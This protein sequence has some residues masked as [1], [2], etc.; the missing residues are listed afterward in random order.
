MSGSSSVLSPQSSSPSHVH[1]SG[2]HLPLP[3]VCCRSVHST[4]GVGRLVLLAADEDGLSVETAKRNDNISTVGKSFSRG[5]ITR[6][7]RGPID[8]HNKSR[9]EKPR[10]RFLVR[11]DYWR[12]VID[13]FFFST[14]YDPRTI[15]LYRV[16]MKCKIGALTCTFSIVRSSFSTRRF[17]L[18]AKS[19][20][21]YTR[22]MF[23]RINDDRMEYCQKAK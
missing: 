22:T 19:H 12:C 3:Q 1:A 13:Q 20:Y 7:D 14:R 17:S 4:W 8:F 10:R 11:V 2:T 15:L 9:N 23:N 16:G 18:L 6:R 5:N 21:C